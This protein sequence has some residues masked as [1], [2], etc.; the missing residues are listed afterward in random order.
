MRWNFV[1]SSL[2][3]LAFLIT[4]CS[5]SSQLLRV[6]PLLEAQQVDEYIQSQE[7]ELQKTPD[8]AQL[9]YNLAFAYLKKGWYPQAEQHALQATRLAPV[10]GQYFE[11]LGDVS[12][13]KKDYG[14]AIN[15]LTTAVRV[16]KSL[17]S[18]YVKLALVY[19]RL[20]EVERALATLE[21][22]EQREDLNLSITYNLA[23]I[24]FKQKDF[25][26]ALQYVETSVDLAPDHLDSQILRIQIHTATGN[27][28]FSRYLID[29]LLSQRE[30]YYPALHELLKIYYIQDQVEGATEVIQKME[31]L[32][33]L[34]NHDRLLLA[35]IHIQRQQYPQAET[36]LNRIIQKD[37]INTGALMGMAELKMRQRKNHEGFEWLNK[38]LQIDD[39]IAQ[40]YFLQAVIHFENNNFLH[41]DIA[42]NRA[43]QLDPQNLKFQLLSLK[44]KL[45]DG[46]NEA[47]LNKLKE[48]KKQQ[49]TNQELLTL[50]ADV[51]M[52]TGK[53]SEAEELLR[54]MRVI[55]DTPEL[56]FSLARVYYFQGHYREVLKITRQL[57]KDHPEDW[58]N[59]YLHVLALHQLS[60]TRQALELLIPLKNEK[61][62]EGFIHRQ[63][64][65]FHRY[66]NEDEQ[67]LKAYQEGLDKFPTQVYLV[68]ALSKAYIETNRWEQ[69]RD[70]LL[71]AAE[72]E[73][74]LQA[75]LFSRLSQVF[76]QLGQKEQAVKYLREYNDKMDPV[77][78]NQIIAPQLKLLFPLTTSTMEFSHQTIPLVPQ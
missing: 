32:G 36:I 69:A 49:P 57:M 38:A 7:A 66:L 6:P 62:G 23:R 27:Y 22:A 77:F 34:Q 45:I 15:S 53:L 43:L 70:V 13:A 4:A 30:N 12:V 2:F 18:A 21:E 14:K 33:H 73:G 41:G 16:D 65:D 50:E 37:P 8:N 71:S 63:I 74:P 46:Q 56:S 51:K 64:G 52:V 3:L 67:A 25:G 40:A 26:K 28:Y 48:L 61:H 72:K 1:V 78:R 55:R 76:R 11:L 17:I 9:H 60:F 68:D 44:R 10:V 47:V 19:E 75:I 5:D 59:T 31:D 39:R 58:E 29:Q 20:H 24:S 35:Y 54:Q 42:I